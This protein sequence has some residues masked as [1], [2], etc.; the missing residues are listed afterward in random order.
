MVLSAAV[1]Y[2]PRNPLAEVAGAILVQAGRGHGG[3]R[4]IAAEIGMA[5]GGSV[6]VAFV[7]F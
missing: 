2:L 1:P 3:M 6:A 4:D 7:G 5:D